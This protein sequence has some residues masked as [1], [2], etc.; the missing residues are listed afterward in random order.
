MDVNISSAQAIYNTDV[1]GNSTPAVS[2]STGDGTYP[3]NQSPAKLFDNDTTTVYSIRVN[4]TVNGVQVGKKTGFYVSVAGC[5]VVLTAFQFYPYINNSNRDP[6]TI[7]IEGSNAVD[8]TKGTNW[9][10][11]YDGTSGLNETNRNDGTL[12]NI[13]NARSFTS[14]RFL[15]N[16]IRRTNVNLVSYS[17]V[18][19]FGYKT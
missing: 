9:E 1:G 18:K 12:Q 15:V 16:D 11:L 10:L 4:Y 5:Q 3:A 13:S 2:G 7:T 19:L 14:Y 6:I 17:E 8:L